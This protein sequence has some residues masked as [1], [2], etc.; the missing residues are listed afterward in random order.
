M[1]GPFADPD[2]PRLDDEHVVADVAFPDDLLAVRDDEFRF[3][4]GAATSLLGAPAGRFHPLHVH[5]LAPYERDR[6]GARTPQSSHRGPPPTWPDGAVQVEA[7]AGQ[8]G[9][10]IGLHVTGGHR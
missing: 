4:G 10:G 9:A 5:R 3:T 2:L 6:A 8:R 7:A 1:G